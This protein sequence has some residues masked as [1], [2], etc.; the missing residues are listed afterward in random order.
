MKKFSNKNFIIIGLPCSGKTMV[1]RRLAKL[2]KLDWI[3]TD[4]NIQKLYHCLTGERI[5]P[6]KIYIQ[7]GAKHF[8]TM[9]ASVLRE[10]KRQ[11]KVISLGGGMLNSKENIKCAKKLGTLIYLKTSPDIIWERLCLRK[12][13]QSF[14]PEIMDIM[15]PLNFKDHFLKISNR[16]LPVYEKLADVTVSTHLLSPNQIANHIKKIFNE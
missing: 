12:I 8:L 16:R 1:G 3:D 15:H 4:H 9:E 7:E 2:L 5:R 11:K 10:L 14:I 13:P 6:R